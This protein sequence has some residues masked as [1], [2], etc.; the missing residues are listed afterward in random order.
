LH[1]LGDIWSNEDLS[2]GE[3]LF[4]TI[5]ALASATGLAVNSFKQLK[6][7]WSAASDMFGKYIKKKIKADQETQ[8]SNLTTA[9]TE[10]VKAAAT[11]DS[12]DATRESAN[13]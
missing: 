1:G 7:G 13:A 6:D 12:A 8:G 11:R 2:T 10:E 3:K 5:V 4:R 9:V